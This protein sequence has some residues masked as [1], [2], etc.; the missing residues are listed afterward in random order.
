MFSRNWTGFIEYNYIDFDKKNE[1]FPLGAPAVVT[2]NA[3]LKNTLSV[4]KVGINY[5]F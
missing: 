5:K 1:S 3:D 2:I 4:A